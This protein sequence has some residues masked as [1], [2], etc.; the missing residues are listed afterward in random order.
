M[1]PVKEQ[2]GRVFTVTV[3]AELELLQEAT[4]GDKTSLKKNV[5]LAPL[6]TAYVEEVAPGM[7]VQGPEVDGPDCH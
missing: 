5:P 4:L 2:F 7:S 3:A 6:G 1:L